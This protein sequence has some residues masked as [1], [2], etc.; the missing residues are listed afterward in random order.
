MIEQEG[1]G[2]TVIVNVFGVPGH[3]VAPLVLT[4]V[5]VIVAVTGAGPLLT[6]IKA[7][8]IGVPTGAEP[9]AANPIV[10]LLFTQL[11]AVAFVP[12]RTTWLVETPL[13]TVWFAIGS[14]T[15]V[16]VCNT[17]NVAGFEKLASQP[18]LANFARNK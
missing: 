9:L 11:Y 10:V 15:T 6:A 18:P 4:G 1:D 5:T 17:V 16:G 7:G 12:V 13:H 14:M 2:F 8:M 3:V